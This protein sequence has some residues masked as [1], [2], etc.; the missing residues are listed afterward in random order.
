MPQTCSICRHPERA[1]IDGQLV[2]AVPL[3]TIAVQH[4]VSKSALVRHNAEHIPPAVAAVQEAADAVRAIDIMAEL[5]RCVAR[6][7]KLFDACDRW[8]TDPDTPAQY[9]IGPRAEDVA[10]TYTTAGPDGKAFRQK[11]RLSALL[12]RVEAQLSDSDTQV[13]VQ[14]AEVKQADPREL[15]LKTADRLDGHLTLV[16]KLLGELDER[17]VINVTLSPEWLALRS[18]IIEV[19]EAHPAAR[20]AVV[21]ALREVDSHAAA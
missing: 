8:L 10:V 3:R 5:T 16:A 4:G 1:A 15:I 6:V 19:L 9:E 11:T 21:D 12:E 13:R 7:N 14:W 18:T 17:A 2:N 20:L